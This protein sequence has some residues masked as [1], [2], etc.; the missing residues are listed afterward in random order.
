MESIEEVKLQ[1]AKWL[2]IKNSEQG[3]DQ[4]Q[5]SAWY[6]ANA[7]HR[8][9]Y[10][11]MEEDWHLLEQLDSCA[12]STQYKNET[13]SSNKIVDFTIF[14]SSRLVISSLAASIVLFVLSFNLFNTSTPIT[15]TRL[16][17][18]LEVQ[19]GIV[20]DDNSIVDLNAS[21]KIEVEF[22]KQ[23]RLIK[24]LKGDATFTVAKDSSRPFVVQY[25]DYKIT[26]LGTAFT[27]NTRPKLQLIVTEHTVKV[28]TPKASV[29]INQ[30]HGIEIDSGSVIQSL[31]DIDIHLGWLNNELAFDSLPLSDVIATIQ[32]YI[33]EQIH[34]VNIALADQPVSG[35][36]ELE[37]PLHIIN[38]IA[39]GLNLKVEKS[40]DK[41]L[42][43]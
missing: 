21:S 36:F 9:I 32:P 2:N 34:L 25:K 8:I 6:N 43:I 28:E 26:A 29:E 3:F 11:D 22:S 12:V 13:E 30:G 20:L 27:V 18:Q 41:L 40:D 31:D 23:Q 14:K 37:D 33:K 19:N 35:R 38:L 42:I 7:I 15:Q 17:S 1:A 39:N 16:V 5:F 24:I 10:N 4:S